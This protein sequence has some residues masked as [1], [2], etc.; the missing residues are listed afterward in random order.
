LKEIY[1]QFYSGSNM[2]IADIDNLQN[3]LDI[4]LKKELEKE[5]WSAYDAT[6]P[7]NQDMVTSNTVGSVSPALRNSNNTNV[8]VPNL[9]NNNSSVN[10]TEPAYFQCGA[11]GPG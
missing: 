9:A 5:E 11:V 3:Y 7:M 1:M 4:T 8:N 2:W 10:Y 6:T